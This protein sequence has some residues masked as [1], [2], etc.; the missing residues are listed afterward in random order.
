MVE[1][2]REVASAL[3]ARSQSGRVTEHLRKRDLRVDDLLAVAV[4]HR[5]DAASSA[6]D[7]A[8]HVA[9]VLVGVVTSTAIMG[10]SRTGSAFAAPSL[11]AI[12]PA[13]LN[14]ISDESTS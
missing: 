7:R 11:S 13:I 5:L 8:E 9:E 2:H 12:E 10:S 6:V 4:F 3:R 14:A 1:L